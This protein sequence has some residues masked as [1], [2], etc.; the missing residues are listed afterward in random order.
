M[1][2]EFFVSHASEDKDAIARPLSNALV[3]IGYR[4]WFDEFELHLGASLRERI[5]HGLAN[6]RFG[7]VVLSPAFF[8]KKWPRAELDAIFSQDDTDHPRLLPVWHNLAAHEVAA[9]SPLLASRVAVTSDQGIQYIR[10]R[11][12]DTVLA[13]GITMARDRLSA[14]LAARDMSMLRAFVGAHYGS[15]LSLIRRRSECLYVRPI[16]EGWDGEPPDYVIASY[17]PT[18]RSYDLTIVLL[19]PIDGDPAVHDDF[20][21]EANRLQRFALERVVSAALVGRD[22]V[23]EVETFALLSRREILARSRRALAHAGVTIRSY[24]A[25]LDNCCT[26]RPNQVEV[27]VES[28]ISPH[29]IISAPPP[30]YY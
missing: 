18:P 16:L 2:W 3:S 14:A 23:P 9:S 17:C 19:G 27:T 28:R 1:D 10:D 22:Y 12:V 4:V 5:D 11:I 7:I 29:D 30:R 15:V 6:S 13:A 24:D 25:L 20:V 21:A 8:K 26:P